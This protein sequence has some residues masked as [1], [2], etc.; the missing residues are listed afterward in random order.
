MS[1][2]LLDF[3]IKVSKKYLQTLLEDCKYDIKENEKKNLIN[4]D[5]NLSFSDDEYDD[6]SNNNSSNNCDD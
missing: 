3:F 5:L 2:L 4:D 1:L 6:R